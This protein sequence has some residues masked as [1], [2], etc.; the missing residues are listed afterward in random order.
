MRTN[1]TV[2]SDEIRHTCA[3]IGIHVNLSITILIFNAINIDIH[4]SCIGLNIN[5]EKNIVKC[6]FMKMFNGKA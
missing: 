3:C 4:T 1:L 5:S 2:L 6:V